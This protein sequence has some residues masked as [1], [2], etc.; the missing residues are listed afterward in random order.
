MKGNE[1]TVIDTIEE[2]TVHVQPHRGG[3]ARSEAFIMRP[4]SGRERR[5]QLAEGAE[6]QERR[7]QFAE[8]AAPF[9]LDFV[10]QERAKREK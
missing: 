9:R 8:G 2:V 7:G 6:L 10:V 1:M 3:T 4:W 5:G